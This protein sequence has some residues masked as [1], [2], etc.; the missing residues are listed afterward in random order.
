[1]IPIKLIASGIAAVIVLVMAAIFWPFV[2]VHAGH[3][4]VVVLFG[5]VQDAVLAPGM[6]V[7]NP[8]A[9]VIDMDVRQYQYPIEGEV[10][11]KD[12]QS[13]HGKVIV[14]Y[15][16]TPE[17]MGRLYSNFGAKYDEII[18]AP[19]VQDRMKAVTPHYN[20]EE[21]VTKRADVSRQ[22][23]AAVTDAVRERSKGLLVVDDVVVS[24]FGFAQSFKKAIEDK[25]VAE[26]LALKAERDLQR[27]KVEAEQRVATAKAEAETFRL[28][29]QQI[30]PQMLQMEAVQKWD[31]VL[32]QIIGGS[33]VPFIQLPMKTAKAAE[34]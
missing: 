31:G 19:A 3:V 15:H 25:Q 4:G 16:P 17:L 18:I 13:V 27:I 11:T 33:A 34:Q 7:V 32:P 2:S 8:M 12:L 23:K 1:V 28:K 29:S 30:T 21:L 26:Q 14:N 10:G 9:H 22:I 6:H 24:D 20:A 5:Q